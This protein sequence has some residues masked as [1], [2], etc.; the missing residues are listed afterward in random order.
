MVVI[1]ADVD[2][3]GASI[4]LLASEREGELVYAGGASLAMSEKD[5][6]RLT[7]QFETLSTP[8]AAIR[9]EGRKNATWIKPKVRVRVRH[10]KGSGGLRHAMVKGFA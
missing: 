5:R 4:A 1:G 3:F 8:K 2:Q 6:N 9:L 10:L 7:K